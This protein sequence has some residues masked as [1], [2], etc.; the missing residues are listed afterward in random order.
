M[1][2]FFDDFETGSSPATTPRLT[3]TE[4]DTTAIRFAQGEGVVPSQPVARGGP[5]PRLMV[6]ITKADI[7]GAQTNVY[8]LVSSFRDHYDI[9]LVVGSG[10]L[11]VKRVEA[12]G[13]PT[14]I[15][16]TLDRSINPL[17]DIR[18]VK[19]LR[20]LIRSFGPQLIHAHSTKAGFVA[21]ITGRIERVPVV[22]TAHGWVFSPGFPLGLRMIA[23]VMEFVS[24][25]LGT[26][27]V[28]VSH[29]DRSLAKKYLRM[30]DEQVSVVPCGIGRKAAAADPVG[31][32]ARLIMV[33]RFDDPK[34]HEMAIRC[35]AR[36]KPD[37]CVLKLVGSGP[38]MEDAIGLVSELKVND[39][40]E[41][42][43]DCLDVPDLLGESD[44]F[45]LFT[46]HE[47]LPI[48]IL[49]AMRA[50]LPVVASDVGGIN[51][52][53]EDHRS[54][55]LVEP[56]NLDKAAEAVKLLVEDVQ[57]RRRM[58]AA[59]RQTFERR[60]TRATM[61]EHFAEIYAANRTHG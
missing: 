17:A 41:F 61:I 12:L 8:D 37:S 13:L 49:E 25:R 16:P 18:C 57:L 6:V 7:G 2:F 4:G 5:K 34:D 54:G 58:G 15:V 45:L 59:G 28:C 40:V 53:V 60:F 46:R 35:I 50:G 14:T 51:E 19:R 32:P 22:Y 48:S 33:A 3:D 11:L 20:R 52:E 30:P 1:P 42:L 10:G 38:L 55:I 43:G 47:G 29:Y 26:H 23:W 44:V 21:R 56:G 24:S 36:L 9:H 39:Q 27:V 31:T